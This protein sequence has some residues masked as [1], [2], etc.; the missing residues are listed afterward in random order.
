MATTVEIGVPASPVPA[1]LR[2]AGATGATRAPLARLPFSAG[3]L[4]CVVML[5]Q[6]SA[7]AIFPHLYRDAAWARAAWSGNDWVTLLVGVPSLFFAWATARNGSAR[8][9]LVWFGALAYAVYNDAY[10]LF[11]AALNAFFPLYVAAFVLA[12]AAL[13]R[14]IFVFEPRVVSAPQVSTRVA[15]TW[16]GVVAFGLAVAWLG[17]W[18]AW[19]ATGA[20]QSIGEDAFRLIAALD[21]TVMVPAM[22]TA[23]VLAWRGS[24]WAP[25]A[26]V[27]AGLQGGLYT[28]VLAA[29]SEAGVRA[30]LPGM[31][32]QVPIW[33]ALTLVTGAL[34][35]WVVW[36]AQTATR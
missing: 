29:G 24:A 9:T 27:L 32:E 20:M 5:V 22:A 1:P 14:S 15:G 18:A 4:L 7:G 33:V 16:L 6:A 3:L 2:P 8:G 35:S 36:R 10:Y 25:V 12:I 23:A 28:L 13:V 31:A 17:Q 19:L 11:G 21:L 34:T 30:G 26:C